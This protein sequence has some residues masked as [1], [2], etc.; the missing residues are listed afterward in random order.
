MLKIIISTITE[1]PPNEFY[2]HFMCLHNNPSIIIIPI[3]VAIQ[4]YIDKD[5]APFS[6]SCVNFYIVT[7]KLKGKLMGFEMIKRRVT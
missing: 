1:T 6:N 5:L 7:L 3:A 2:L 4:L